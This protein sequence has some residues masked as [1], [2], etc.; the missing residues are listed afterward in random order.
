MKIVVYNY[1]YQFAL[2][3]KQIEVIKEV[4]PKEYFAP[5]REFHITTRSPGQERFEFD[6]K[7]KTAHFEYKVN[8]KTDELISDALEHLLIGLKR[9]KEKDKFGHFI[10]DSNKT[11]YEAFIQEWKQK[12]FYEIKKQS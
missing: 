10:K 5:I 3:R 9:I 4:L 12:C 8:Q 2:S 1:Q 6:Y 7:T 11:E